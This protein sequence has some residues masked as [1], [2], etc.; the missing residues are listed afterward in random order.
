MNYSVTRNSEYDFKNESS[1]SVYPNLHKYPATMLPQ[2][3]MKILK[4]LDI[5]KGVLLDPYCGTGS[6]LTVGL[7]C[8][9]LEMDG[10]DLNPLAVLISKGK[11]TKIDLS[12]VK[13]YQERLMEEV[14]EFMKKQNSELIRAPS[15]KNR[16]FW[17]SETISKKLAIIQHFVDGIL[18]E[19]VK[20]LF[21]IPLSETIRG[22]SYTRNHE[23]KLYR[24]KAEELKSFDPDVF[25]IY[26]QKLDETISNYEDYYHPLLR[27]CA[28]IEIRNDFFK[29]RENHY[30][31]VLTSPPYGDSKTTVSYGQFSQ[32]SNEWFRE[33]SA[34]GLDRML[35]G[36][37][38]NEVLYRRGVMREKIEEIAKICY[39]RALEVSGFY[40]DLGAGIDE[41]A[42]S[43]R[44]GGKIIYIVGNRRV[45]GIQLPTNQFIAERFEGNGFRHI[46]TYERILGK[47]RMPLEN[48]PTNEKNKRSKTM[49]EEYIVVCEKF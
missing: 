39:S 11:T 7:D 10:F 22:C 32:F 34:R 1:G 19:G 5:K 12:E 36:G 3:G 37:R 28:K 38:K 21:L 31:V 13:V 4:E 8:G 14:F 35:L 42:R 26:F 9:I 17:F 47:K 44:R 25:G 24:M 20:R 27:D 18:G 40:R 23:F 33:S 16:G 43:V 6:S 45:K 15:F 46:L 30:D 2:I 41:V 29:A 48:S 49:Q